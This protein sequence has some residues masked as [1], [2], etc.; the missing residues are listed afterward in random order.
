[1][2]RSSLMV[3]LQLQH[4]AEQGF[5]GLPVTKSKMPKPHH[6]AAMNF[7]PSVQIFIKHQEVRQRYGKVINALRLEYMLLPVI[8]Q[9]VKPA[10]GFILPAKPPQRAP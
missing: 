9:L 2:Q 4:L 6:V 5:R 10:A 7:V 3:R 8:D 1:M